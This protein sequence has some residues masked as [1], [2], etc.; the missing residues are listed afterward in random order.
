MTVTHLIIMI[1][2]D[3]RQMLYSIL[4]IAAVYINLYFSFVKIITI[5][6]GLSR[7][8]FRKMGLEQKRGCL[9]CPSTKGANIFLNADGADQADQNGSN[10][11]IQCFI[12]SHRLDPLDPLDP[13]SNSS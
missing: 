12:R 13:R 6:Y 4:F 10:V 3:F 9:K 5:Y 2:A 1:A 8:D 11:N 7:K